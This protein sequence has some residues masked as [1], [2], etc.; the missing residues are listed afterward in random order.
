LRNWKGENDPDAQIMSDMLAEIER[1]TAILAE[2]ERLNSWDAP[3]V[4]NPEHA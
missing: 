1:L 4:G 3:A 2:I